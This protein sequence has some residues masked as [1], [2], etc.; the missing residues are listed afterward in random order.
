[1][2]AQI[3]ERVKDYSMCHEYAP[4]QQKEPLIPSPVPDLP[5]EVAVSD[6]LTFEGQQY[7]VAVDYYSKYIEVTKLNDLTSL[8]IIRALKEHVSRHGIPAKLITDCGAQ[9]ASK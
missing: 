6:I 4:A 5:W 1:M 9:Y 3:E 2:S 7:L 8:E